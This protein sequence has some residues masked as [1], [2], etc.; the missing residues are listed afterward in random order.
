MALHL[1]RN[2]SNESSWILEVGN[3]FSRASPK[4]GRPK[5]LKPMESYTRKILFLSPNLKAEVT[6]AV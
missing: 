3:K 6:E 5:L 2:V 4:K 1:G